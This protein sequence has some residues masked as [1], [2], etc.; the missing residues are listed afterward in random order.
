MYIGGDISV[1][2]GLHVN[3]S[4]LLV[5][6]VFHQNQIGLTTFTRPLHIRCLKLKLA[7]SLYKKYMGE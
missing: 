3:A 7:F 1:H 4:L 5:S 6:V 2:R